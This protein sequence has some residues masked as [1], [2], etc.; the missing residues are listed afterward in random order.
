MIGEGMIGVGLAARG[1][2]R[3]CGAGDA[4]ARSSLTNRRPADEA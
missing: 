4:A 2:T 3:G 1:T